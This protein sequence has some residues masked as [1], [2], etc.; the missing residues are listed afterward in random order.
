LYKLN[1]DMIDEMNYEIHID[2]DNIAINNIEN[3]IYGYIKEY[4]YE[5]EFIELYEVI[6]QYI[7]DLDFFNLYRL[8]RITTNLYDI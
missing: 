3:Y 7:D 6:N 1:I 4:G 8:K 5:P 2:N